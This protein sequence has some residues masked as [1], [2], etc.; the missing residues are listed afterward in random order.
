MKKLFL[1]L[2]GTALLLAACGGESSPQPASDLTA[3]TI[4]LTASQS[5]TTVN[6]SAAAADNVGVTK[7]E[8]YRGSTLISTDTASPYTFTDTVNAANNRNV[9]Y[10]AKAYDAAGNVG[11]DSKTVALT[12][13]YQGQ[14]YW[15]LITDPNDPEGSLLA[16]GAAIFD[17]EFTGADG[18]LLGAGAY[19]EFNS[20]PQMQGDAT[21]GK[22]MI[23]G[24]ATLSNAFF[25]DLEETKVYLFATDNDGVFDLSPDGDPIFIGEAATFGLDGK[26]IN[27]GY[28]GL[29]RIN[30]DPNAVTSLSGSERGV[31]K[32]ELLAA[33]KSSGQLNHPLK[34]AGL[35]SGTA[36]LNRLEW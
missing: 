31:A 12:T 22:I 5:G 32:T 2:I 28:F 18:Q 3:P 9:S 36:Q 4:T 14:Y 13:A 23:S 7:V 16:E 26:V 17:L 35:K 8:F 30:E 11:Q 20:T 15:A 27:E 19:A 10:S 34:L 33:L 21:L 25:Y 1:P 6:L 29:L 24:E